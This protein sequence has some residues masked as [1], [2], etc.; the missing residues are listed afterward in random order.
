MEDFR[1]MHKLHIN[2][3]K[4][5]A[6]FFGIKIYL[7]NHAFELAKVLYD[8]PTLISYINYMGDQKSKDCN[9]LAK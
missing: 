9:S 5:K 7:Q 4:L 8:N 6:I 3:L 1:T 2:L